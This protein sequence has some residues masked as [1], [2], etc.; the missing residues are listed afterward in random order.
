MLSAV[1][2][3]LFC[4]LSSSAQLQGKRSVDLCLWDWQDE[5]NQHTKGAAEPDGIVYCS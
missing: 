4:L 2:R 1:V 5:V 3:L